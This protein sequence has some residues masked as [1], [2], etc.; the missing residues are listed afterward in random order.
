MLMMSVNRCLGPRGKDIDAA[1]ADPAAAV[2]ETLAMTAC[3]DGARGLLV[4]G[5]S[6]YHI[7]EA[8]VRR[9][10]MLL[11]LSS[12]ISD[13]ESVHIP[14]SE[15]DFQRWFEFTKGNDDIVGISDTVPLSPS[16]VAQALKVSCSTSA[17]WDVCVNA[18]LGWS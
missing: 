17:R 10:E 18:C 2:H 14:I 6:Q 8:T 5:G 15:Q 3:T 9:S 16:V 13:Q 1:A 11:S 4:Q 12:V 7:H